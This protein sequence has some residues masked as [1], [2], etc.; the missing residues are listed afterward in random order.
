PPRRLPAGPDRRG[1][2]AARASSTLEPVGWAPSAP[3]RAGPQRGGLARRGRWGVLHGDTTRRRARALRWPPTRVAAARATAPVAAAARRRAAT[4]RAGRHGRAVPPAPAARR[5]A[6][7]APAVPPAGPGTR[8]TRRGG[9]RA[10]RLG[11]RQ[12]TVEVGV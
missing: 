2:P 7:S 3:C 5:R 8:G 6:R 12:L 11:L 10:A 4:G 1:A 9:P